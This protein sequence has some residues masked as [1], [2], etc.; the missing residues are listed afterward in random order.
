LTDEFIEHAFPAVFDDSAIIKTNKPTVV[1]ADFR[2]RD[3][4][5]RLEKYVIDGCYIAYW[6][7]AFVGAR[8]YILT[9]GTLERIP[10]PIP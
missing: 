9:R 5:L 3:R 2:V 1:L 8:R 6:S 4:L 10:E 7:V